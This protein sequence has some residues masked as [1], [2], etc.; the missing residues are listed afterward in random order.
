MIV[1]DSNSTSGTPSN[2]ISFGFGSSVDTNGTEDFTYKQAYPS[3]VSRV[4]AMRIQGS[5]G[6][7]G[8]NITSP[9]EKLDVDGNIR[10]HGNI[11]SQTFVSGFAG[12]GFRIT[13]GSTYSTTTDDLTVRGTMNVYELLI[14]QIRAT[15]G[16]L[17]VSNTG[18]ITSA[19]LSSNNL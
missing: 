4:E 10:T 1:G 5:D 14:N 16:S 15:N 18:K 6:N 3:N 2:N 19:S 17:F 9:S 7:V 12:S 11:S 8:I 13:S